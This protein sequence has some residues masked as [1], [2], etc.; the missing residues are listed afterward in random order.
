M[1][2]KTRKGKTILK[3]RVLTKLTNNIRKSEGSEERIKELQIEKNNLTVYA[4]LLDRMTTKAY[5]GR[6]MIIAHMLSTINVTVQ[7]TSESNPQFI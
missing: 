2:K 6:Y 7:S 3:P 5:R 4:L 1:T